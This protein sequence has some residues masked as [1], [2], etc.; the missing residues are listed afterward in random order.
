MMKLP[1]FS[2]SGET[3]QLVIV[4]CI[5]KALLLV[6]AAFCPGPGYDTSALVLLDS[7]PQRHSNFNALTRHERFVLNL[8]R[9]DAFYFVKS[10]ERG[11]VHEQAWAFSWAYSHLLRL[12][13]QLTAG[14]AQPSLH[15]YVLA[16][17]VASNVCHLLSVL[18]LYRLLT[19]VLEPQRRQII[20]FIAAVLHILTPAS[21]FLCAP[22]AEAM[23][24]F[25]NF[26]GMLF[27]AQSRTMA[28]TGKSSFGEDLL[29]I[30]SGL[31]FAVAT[32]MRSNGLLSGTIFLYDVA[33]YLPRLMSLQLSVHDVRRVT[34]TCVA[35]ALIALGFI[36]PQ[37][38]A[39]VEF[40]Y[41]GSGAGIRP[42]C[43]KSVPSIYTW[44]QSH[45]WNVGLFRYWTVSNLPLFILA[46][47]VMWLLLVSSATILRSAVQS[48]LHGRLAPQASATS[49]PRNEI[50][51]ICKM[52]ELALPQLLLAIT[53]VTSFH[54]QIVNR[55]A[56]GYPMWYLVIAQWLV[57]SQSTGRTEKPSPKAQWIIRGFIVYSLVQGMLY[58]NF[59]PP[60]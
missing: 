12:A 31:F 32:L 52:P 11:H 50:S 42:W 28:E 44:V 60:A 22:Y 48:P 51:T 47:P 10:A 59:L 29:K 37:Y 8:L 36:G 5:W 2:R 20:P 7:S 9:W 13:G 56:S 55:I 6:L 54:I 19:L 15:Y 41:R 46:A 45:Y 38:L 30:S 26:T 39:Y 18:V 16:G 17:I 1:G 14:N 3:K 25:L 57:D 4:S 35:G 58:A 23:F 34:V 43:E 40:C 21:L 53:A 24:S 49:N 27:Y 33:R